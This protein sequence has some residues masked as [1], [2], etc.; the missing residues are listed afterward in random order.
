MPASKPY[1]GAPQLYTHF[2]HL[3]LDGWAYALDADHAVYAPGPY[4]F[5]EEVY[6]LVPNPSA[7]PH[8]MKRALTGELRPT[9]VRLSPD[10]AHFSWGN[11]YVALYPHPAGAAARMH[12]ATGTRGYVQ[13]MWAVLDLDAGRAVLP[14]DIPV[15]LMEQAEVKTGRLLDLVARACAERDAGAKETT[16]V[17]HP[18]RPGRETEGVTR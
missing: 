4:P 7:G 15:D 14:D 16:A 18:L 1:L 3:D 17:L 2:V 13:P 8:A 10:C 9:S 12:L 11:E 6:D 5:R